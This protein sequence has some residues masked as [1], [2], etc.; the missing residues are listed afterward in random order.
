MN[1]SPGKP[2]PFP[3]TSLMGEMVHWGKHLLSYEF[4]PL[5]LAFALGPGSTPWSKGKV[6][7]TIF[8]AADWS[9]FPLQTHEQWDVVTYFINN[10]ENGIEAHST[11]AKKEQVVISV[12]TTWVKQ[13]TQN[14]KES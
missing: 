11:A 14:L 4:H 7:P 13:V 6:S 2:I 3:A 8:P 12:S 1:H 5:S 10:L 9:E